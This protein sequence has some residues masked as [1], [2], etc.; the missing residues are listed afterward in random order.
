MQDGTYGV[1]AGGRDSNGHTNNIEY[2]TI[3]TTGNTT[4]F[5]DQSLT[6]SQM[7]SAS[8]S[9]YGV[10]AGGYPVALGQNNT[11]DYITIATPSNA[12][13]FGDLTAASR[14]GS[15]CANAT[16]MCV[17]LAYSGAFVRNIDY[18]T[19]ETPGNA[20]DFGDMAVGDGGYKSGGGSGA[21]A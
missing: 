17:N 16:R 4:D 21:S 20:A 19:I 18:V 2:I 6:R 13:D 3:Q 14:D 15:A 12:T 5:G 11:I 10:M 8:N 1:I 9:T 7:M